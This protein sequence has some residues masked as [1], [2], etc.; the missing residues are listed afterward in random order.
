MP[1]NK[2]PVLALIPARG[3]SKGIKCKNMKILNGYPLIY[4]TIK[5]ALESRFVDNVFVSSDNRSILEYAKSMKV[6]TL[7][8]PKALSTDSAHPAGVVKNFF[9]FLPL[10]ITS[11][12]PYIVY[13]QP[14]S[15]LRSVIHINSAFLKMKKYLSDTLVS[16][17]ENEHTPF[18]SFKLNEKKRITSLFNE[19]FSNFRRQD[20][21]KT[22]RPN[23][24]IYI[25]KYSQFNSKGNFPSNGALGYVMKSNVSIDID[26]LDD[27][28]KAKKFLKELYAT[29]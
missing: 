3:G 2:H 10:E 11:Q 6:K 12:D 8:R 21:P 29:Y 1:F 17:T 18:K 23:G 13:L 15:P 20:L 25:F 14:T 24:A 28:N 26:S 22:Y 4:F 19:N 27:L 16:I 7:L 9:D 5:A